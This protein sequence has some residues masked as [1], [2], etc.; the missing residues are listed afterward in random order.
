MALTYEGSLCFKHNVE[1]SGESGG[2]EKVC[3]ELSLSSWP[4][5]MENTKERG[6]RA[7]HGITVEGRLL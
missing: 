2:E 4:G 7:D 1:R 5:S 3:R 6:T